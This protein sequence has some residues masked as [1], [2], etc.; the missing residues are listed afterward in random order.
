MDIKE[1]YKFL[2]CGD[3]ISKGV[4]FD[5]TKGKYTVLKDNYVSLLEKN[6]RCNF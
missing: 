1:V 2:L 3:S 5:E 6:K 4:I